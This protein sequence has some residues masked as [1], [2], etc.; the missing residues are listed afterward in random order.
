MRFFLVILMSFIFFTTYSQTYDKPGNWGLQ[1]KR[2]KV[3]TL[4]TVAPTAYALIGNTSLDTSY[5]L[6]VVGKSI[7]DGLRLTGFETAPGSFDGG[8][9][10]YIL[11]QLCA[12]CST[13]T[14]FGVSIHAVVDRSVLSIGNNASFAA[15]DALTSIYSDSVMNM[16]A[17]TGFQNN[18]IWDYPVGSTLGKMYGFNSALVPKRATVNNIYDFYAHHLGATGAPAT[19]GDHYAFY[20]EDFAGGNTASRNHGIHIL[21]STMDNY[22]AGNVGIGDTNRGSYKL[23]VNGSA[24]IVNNIV[25]GDSVRFTDYGTSSPNDTVLSANTAGNLVKTHLG[26][27]YFRNGGNSFGAAATIGTND[28]FGLN[29]ETNGTTR[30]S[31]SN[32]GQFSTVQ[33][34]LINNVTIGRGTISNTDILLGYQ[35]GNSSSA[36]LRNTFIGY[37]AGTSNATGDRNIFIGYRSG[38]TSTIGHQNT[39]VGYETGANI[40]SG[41]RYNTYLGYQAGY[42]DS[43]C[44]HNTAIGYQSLNL[45]K[46]TGANVAVGSFSLASFVGA[47]NAFNTALGFGAGRFLTSGNYNLFL[48]GFTGTGFETSSNNIWLSDGQGNVRIRI[49]STGNVLIKST[50]DR[51][52][53]A[54]QV[55]GNV[56]VLGS[57]SSNTYRW[58]AASGS[59]PSNTATPAGWVIINVNGSTAYLPYYQ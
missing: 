11:R 47:T 44:N 32:S 38:A 21:G 43:A 23:E 9:A 5:K 37:Q 41:S 58:D 10:L 1:Y 55:T 46:F 3:D 24:N 33:N 45:A 14:A 42:S 16:S 15:F 28:N 26:T 13:D 54:L 17:M 49:P 27:N 18:S 6:N 2:V 30:A 50:T 48:G 56:S 7:I 39:F 35:V 36:D 4:F 19:I 51:G 12:G 8:A 57:N 34:A 40:A 53:G 59:T 31:I 52:T 22:F 20:S 25:V 29:F